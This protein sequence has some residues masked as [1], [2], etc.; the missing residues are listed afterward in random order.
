[1]RNKISVLLFLVLFSPR[2]SWSGW[3]DKFV[4]PDGKILLI[5]GQDT[6]AIEA[7]MKSVKIESGGFA[8]YTS[9]QSADGLTAPADNG[10]G[11]QHAEQIANDHPN[12]VIQLALYMV[13]ACEAVTSGDADAN[14]DAIGNWIKSTKRPVYLRIGYEFDL[15]EN[16]Y[17]PAEYIKAYRHIVDRFRK[18]GVT[19]VA[20]VWHSYAQKIERPFEDWYPGDN[21]VDWFAVSYFDQ[22]NFSAMN[23]FA[24]LADLHKKP[25]M[26]AESSPWRFS[27]SVDSR[28][29]AAWFIPIMDFIRN[30]HVK[31]WSYINCDW[32]QLPLF[33]TE[34]WGDTRVQSNPTI[35][36]LWSEEISKDRY[37]KASPDLF[38]KLGYQP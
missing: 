20:Y 23:R 29:W 6:E 37:L 24:E 12:S 34:G 1:M 10:G 33:K 35:R 36:K 18:N 30:K 19:N 3:D 32:D 2:P 21:Y 11:I 16:H 5:T 31:I 17:K 4:P 38:E 9:I 28:A 13:D 8:A 26:I 14:V 25:L 22:K 7:Y 15:P 27:T